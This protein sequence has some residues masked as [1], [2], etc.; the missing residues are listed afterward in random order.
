MKYLLYGVIANPG[1]RRP[2]TLL[3]VGG[4]P[5]F[6]VGKDGLRAAVSRIPSADL[7]PAISRILAYEK[8]LESLHR[9]RAV[10]PLR[11]GSAFEKPS[12]ILEFLEEHGQQY[13]ALLRELEGCVEMGIRALFKKGE[14][15]RPTPELSGADYLA[16][17]RDRYAKRDRLTV[18]QERIKKKIQKL[19]SGLFV[20]SKMESSSIAGRQL[21]SLH[22]LVPKKSLTLFRKAF[23]GIGVP[24]SAKL[25]LSGPWPPHNFVT[26]GPAPTRETVP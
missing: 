17:Q 8:V 6:L 25:L 9:R 2:K 20:R 26:E 16:A 21:L 22:F 23:Q 13:Q 15:R 24:N 10:I 5:V 11:Y 14:R 1:P 18:Q 19:L 7:A 12:Q 4:Q 3:G